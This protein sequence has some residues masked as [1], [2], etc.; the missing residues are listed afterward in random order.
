MWGGAGSLDI[1]PLYLRAPKKPGVVA[2]GPSGAHGFLLALE[3]SAL[4]SRQAQGPEGT[5]QVGRKGGRKRDREC[6]CGD[7]VPSPARMLLPA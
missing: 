3:S 7:P 6:V 4:S 1:L 2:P 5:T